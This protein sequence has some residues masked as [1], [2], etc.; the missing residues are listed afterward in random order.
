MPSAPSA[1]EWWA[2]IVGIVLLFIS[3]AWHPPDPNS[4]PNTGGIVENTGFNDLLYLSSETRAN[5]F[6]WSGKR[7]WRIILGG[8]RSL[9][10]MLENNG[11]A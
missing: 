9:P 3:L 1:R 4:V 10:N 7:S 8:S 5:C 2:T 6:A 11:H